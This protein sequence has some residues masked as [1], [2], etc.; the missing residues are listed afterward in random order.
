VSRETVIAVAVS[1]VVVGTMAIDHLVGTESEP[2]ET[3][4]ADPGAFVLGVV[5]ALVLVALFFG[6]VVPR[7]VRAEPEESTLKSVAFSLLAVLTLPLV[8]LAVPFP[9]A[10]AGLA[11]GLHARAG[12]HWVLATAAVVAGGFVLAL[13]AVGYLVAL[14][15]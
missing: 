4:L 1:A 5:L 9:F 12:R 7:A 2:G 8:F 6:R 14:I 10:G 15:A 13:G 11:L 3:G